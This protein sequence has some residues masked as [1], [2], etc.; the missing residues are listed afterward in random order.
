M[1]LT[2]NRE[3]KNR[4]DMERIGNLVFNKAGNR[5][6]QEAWLRIKEL[7]NKLIDVHYNGKTN[8]R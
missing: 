8:S 1:V 6:D 4:D 7:M 5:K 3:F 2:A